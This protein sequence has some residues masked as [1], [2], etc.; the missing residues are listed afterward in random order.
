MAML[1]VFSM[2]VPEGTDGFILRVWVAPDARF[3]W[4]VAAQALGSMIGVWLL[5]RGYQ[6]AETS[7]VSVF[8]FSLLIF[9]TVWAYVLRGE[10]LDLW[11]VAGIVLIIASGTAIVLRGR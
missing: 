5:I 3:L 7:F 2:T 11:A 10:T 6:L 4:L 8:E 9:V 1:S